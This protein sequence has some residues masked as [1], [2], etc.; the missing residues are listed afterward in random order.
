MADH[1]IIQLK[2]NLEEEKKIRNSKEKNSE[3][4]SH[5]QNKIIDTLKEN[6]KNLTNQLSSRNDELANAREE[7]NRL[8]NA[9]HKVEIQKEL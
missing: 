2:Q 3:S 9:Q 4:F 8:V 5:A 6:N 1:K 7:I